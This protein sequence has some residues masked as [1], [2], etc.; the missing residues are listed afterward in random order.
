MNQQDESR[1]LEIIINKI[2]CIEEAGIDWLGTDKFFA[3]IVIDDGKHPTQ[4]VKLPEPVSPAAY[5][6]FI[7]LNER[8][9]VDIN[10]SIYRVDDVGPYIKIEMKGYDQSTPT[11]RSEDAV[12][13]TCQV[14]FSEAENWGKGKQHKAPCQLEQD[15]KIKSGVEIYYTIK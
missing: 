13:G 14:Q 3:E 15:G 8:Q 2:H 4:T 9:T 12:I 6:T 5:Q 1:M 7:P 10:K 11:T